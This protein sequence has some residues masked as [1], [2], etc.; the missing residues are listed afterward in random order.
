MLLQ[1]AKQRQASQTTIHAQHRRACIAVRRLGAVDRMLARDAMAGTGKASA[2]PIRLTAVWDGRRRHSSDS[3]G[4]YGQQIP[5]RTSPGC[6][7]VANFLG[8]KRS[9]APLFPSALARKIPI[10][11][12][13]ASRRPVPMRIIAQRRTQCRLF[14]SL[15]QAR[16]FWS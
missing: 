7:A 10:C 3:S 2:I 15:L 12:N 16:L 14:A 1:L 9:I 5:S 8:T 4:R 11:V 13:V 6:E